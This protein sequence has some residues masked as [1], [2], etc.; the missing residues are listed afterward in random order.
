[1][2]SS[3]KASPSIAWAA[4]FMLVGGLL[5]FLGSLLI[6][7]TAIQSY[8]DAGRPISGML[9][10][11]LLAYVVLPL[12]FS[13]LAVVASVG[14]FGLRQWACKV[15]IFLSVAPVTTCVLLLLW[16]P[17]AV[18]PSNAGLKYAILTVGSFGDVMYI[19]TTILLIPISI[20]WLILFTR[21]S[22]RS[23]FQ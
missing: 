15:S 10:A 23:Q 19:Y 2:T 5:F 11:G 12:S 21:P 20:W 22:V 14:L 16:R 3:I 18:F 7:V 17:E 6:L 13:L 4:V 1:M 9:N 8:R